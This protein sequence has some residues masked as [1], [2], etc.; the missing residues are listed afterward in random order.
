MG[1]FL[2]SPIPNFFPME[3]NPYNTPS[4]NLFGS[5][6][7]TAQEGVS[8][9]AITQLQRTKPWVRFLSVI[10]WLVVAL[11]LVA[12]LGMILG[13]AFA[14]QALEKASPGMS[15]G[16]MMGLGA[17]YIVFSFLYIY[18]AVK[19]WAYG[20]QIAKLVE[21]RSADH[22]EAALNQQRAVWKFMGIITIVMIVGYV[23]AIIGMVAFSAYMGFSQAGGV[24]ELPTGN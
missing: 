23:V 1:Y 4:A 18:P 16:L 6:A 15:G 24:T 14:G 22:L 9:G 8:Q 17:I 2:R 19:L 13:G 10:M 21:S 5:T 12:A 7:G 20:T 3:N 11:M